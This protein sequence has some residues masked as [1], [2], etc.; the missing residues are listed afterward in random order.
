[1]VLERGAPD[2]SHA[3]IRIAAE[4]REAARPEIRA[5]DGDRCGSRTASAPAAVT[6]FCARSARAARRSSPGDTADLPS[7]PAACAGTGAGLRRAS[8]VAGRRWLRPPARAAAADGRCRSQHRLQGCGCGLGAQPPGRRAASF[9]RREV[10]HAVAQ[11][12]GQSVS[13]RS[14][15]ASPSAAST[16]RR[17]RRRRAWPE[18]AG[19]LRRWLMCPDPTEAPRARRRPGGRP[20]LDRASL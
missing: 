11:R 7:L 8:V 20:G 6:T 3:W 17:R 13:A 18:P 12:P 19:Q 15:P 4:Q 9:T 5:R 16:S 1:M 2:A 14:R 10:V